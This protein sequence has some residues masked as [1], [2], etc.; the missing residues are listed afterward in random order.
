MVNDFDSD[1]PL[2]FIG[3]IHGQAQTL[4]ALLAQLGWTERD[5]RLRH[6][7]GEALV[8][9]GD[10]IDRG[11][12]NLRTVEIVRSLVEQG[13]AICLMG[14]H[15]FNAVLFHT[16]D[17]DQPD[18][19]LREQSEK[20]ILQHEAVL[21]ELDRRPGDKDDMLDW[22]KTL[23]VAVEG[24]GWRCVHA[25]WHAGSLDVL[26]RQGSAWHLPAGRWVAAARDG[27]PEY[28]AIEA[29]LKGPEH[30]LP[31]GAHFLDKEGT[32]RHHAR[33]RWW[34]P[35]P[36]TL[37]EALIFQYRPER[38]DP[39]TLPYDASRHPAYPADAPPVF[40]GHY[41]NPP[42]RIQPER[43]NAVCL[44]YS[45]GKGGDLVAYRME[46]PGPVQS[47]NFIVQQIVR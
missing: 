37:E 26:P 33:I 30:K 2:A 10:L 25:C 14:N 27:E 41:W 20:N 1:R 24:P 8:F 18:Q 23:P 11:P 16:E 6:D 46:T 39:T 3:D 32:P 38:I 7:R 44:D 35:E 4:L 15:E 17:P 36:A 19:H 47:E 5:S 13:D 21:K 12:E 34:E 42:G 28:A 22:F 40:F 31:D 45:V 29:L 43:H 9:V